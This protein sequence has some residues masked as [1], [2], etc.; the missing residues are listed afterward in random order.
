MNNNEPK[1]PEQDDLLSQSERLDRSNFKNQVMTI[2]D[3]SA[4]DSKRTSQQSETSNE[5]DFIRM[6]AS[7]QAKTSQKTQPVSEENDLVSPSAEHLEE[8]SIIGKR[9]S[10]SASQDSQPVS[11]SRGVGDSTKPGASDDQV[12]DQ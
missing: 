3:F 4:I 8:P 5:R 1:L 11:D 10:N 7:Q 2:R 12:K 6:L 9:E